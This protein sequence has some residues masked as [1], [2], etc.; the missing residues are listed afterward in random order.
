MT[1][2]LPQQ[3]FTND[4]F[5]DCHFY[6]WVG[7]HYTDGVIDG[8][9]VL[10]LGESH[11][12]FSLP[13]EKERGLTQLVIQEE[14]DGK[15]RHRFIS[16]VTR[17]LFDRAA[18]TNRARFSSLWNTMAFYNYLQE[19]AGNG[20]RKRPSDAAWHRSAAPFRS[21][22]AALKPDF[23]LAC[24]RALYEHLKLVEG[25][26]SENTERMATSGLGAD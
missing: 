4:D 8:L 25:L 13:V 24:G 26:T 23:V 12:S 19:Y 22:L 9:R 3:R 16:G 7:P 17:A 1:T 2:T 20:P 10:V 5:P 15:M 14:L 11:F 6:P 18:V 21:V